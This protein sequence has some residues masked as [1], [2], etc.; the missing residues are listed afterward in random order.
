MKPTGGR[1]ASRCFSS[2]DSPPSWSAAISRSRS[3]SVDQRL[4]VMLTTPDLPDCMLAAK[5][6]SVSTGCDFDCAWTSATPA[7]SI[8]TETKRARLGRMG[9]LLGPSL[10]GLNFRVED[11]RRAHGD[12]ARARRYRVRLLTDQNVNA[13]W[14]DQPSLVAPSTVAP[15]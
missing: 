7:S 12:R 13:A 8:R 10:F 1:I 4:M 5:A 6:V 2:S 9:V 14:T 3:S 11:S 15:Y